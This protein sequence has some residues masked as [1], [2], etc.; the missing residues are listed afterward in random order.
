[1]FKRLLLKRFEIFEIN[2]YSTSKFNNKT[3]KKIKN[4]SVI[5]KSIKNIYMKY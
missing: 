2:E 5:K 4:V 3:F 1:M